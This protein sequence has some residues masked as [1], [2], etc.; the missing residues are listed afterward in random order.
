MQLKEK[1]LQLQL[2]STPTA[3]PK[4]RKIQTN[5]K[6]VEEITN[7]E[8]ISIQTKD[9]S[10][11]VLWMLHIFR[12]KLSLD[13]LAKNLEF[14]KEPIGTSDLMEKVESYSSKVCIFIM[15]ILFIIY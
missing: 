2:A 1:R 15:F 12:S 13:D 3:S 11:L 10:T 5:T 7:K 9:M 6:P 14:G 4:K 8:S